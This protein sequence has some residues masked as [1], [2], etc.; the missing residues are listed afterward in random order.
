MRKKKLIIKYKY[1]YTYINIIFLEKE[2]VFNIT[3]LRHK[4]LYLIFHFQEA[5][6]AQARFSNQEGGPM[7]IL[8]RT[9]VTPYILIVE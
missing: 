6:S 5:T 3:L 2:T 8:I 7:R 1:L 9:S 4:F